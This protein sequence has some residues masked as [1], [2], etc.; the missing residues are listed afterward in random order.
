MD[1]F[2]PILFRKHLNQFVKAHKRML[3]YFEPGVRVETPADLRQDQYQ[4]LTDTLLSI[5]SSP[6]A[7]SRVLE[8]RQAYAS[9]LS[10]RNTVPF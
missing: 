10:Q 6:E 4:S 9:Y 1:S 5:D 2:N 3:L 8:A 7:L